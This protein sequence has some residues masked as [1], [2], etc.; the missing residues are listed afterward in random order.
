MTLEN[1]GYHRAVAAELDRQ[2]RAGYTPEHDDTQPLDHLLELAFRYISEGKTVRGGALIIAARGWLQRHTKNSMQTDIETFMEACDQE[3]KKYPQLPTEAIRDLRISLIREE[4]EGQGELLESL[5]AGD[6]VGIAD[7]IAD[8]LYVVIGTAVAYGIDIQEVFN[9]VQRSNM[10]KATWDEDN[11]VWFTTRRE[12]G[13]IL[14]PETF[15]PAN[16]EPIILRQI[17]SGKQFESYLND[18]AESDD[19]DASVVVGTIEL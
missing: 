15:S 1:A 14:K 7:G 6:L 2:R 9:E 3:V 12:D 16:L 10:T 18:I 19:E 11:Q 5:L 8:V 13:K 17:E 4:W